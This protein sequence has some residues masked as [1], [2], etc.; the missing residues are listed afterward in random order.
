[1]VFIRGKA[2]GSITY[3]VLASNALYLL[4]VVAFGY[5]PLNLIWLFSLAFVAGFLV[6]L[7][8]FSW[9]LITLG[10]AYSPL[11]CIGL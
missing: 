8:P 3:A 4:A 7:P 10:K 11:S 9:L 2:G 1:V 6:L 5:S